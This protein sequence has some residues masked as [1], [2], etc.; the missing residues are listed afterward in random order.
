MSSTFTKPFYA[1]LVALAMLASCSRPVAYFQRGPVTSSATASVQP[2]TLITQ[3]VIEPAQTEATA[4][5]TAYHSEANVQKDSKLATS[6][7]LNKR[8]IRIGKML[9]ASAATSGSSI[10]VAPH[11]MNGLE[12]LILKKLNRQ[13]GKQLAPSHPQKAMVAKGK[14]A[15]SI[16]LLIAGLLMLILGTGTLAFIGLIVSLVGAVGTIVSLFGTDS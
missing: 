16:V 11:K 2:N 4:N 6:T 5:I 10:T 7:A 14:L 9:A 15:G 1:S 13:L 8:M 12:R 3:H